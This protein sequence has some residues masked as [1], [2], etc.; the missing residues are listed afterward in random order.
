MGSIIYFYPVIQTGIALVKKIRK[1]PT[2]QTGMIFALF[3]VEL[4]LG[5]AVI[6]VYSFEQ[7]VIW[8]ILYMAVEKEYLCETEDNGR[9]EN[10]LNLNEA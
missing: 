4:F 2:Y 8:S 6:F 3:L 10:R 7:L 1:N 9:T 5:S